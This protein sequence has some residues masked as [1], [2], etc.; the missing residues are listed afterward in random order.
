MKHYI[1]VPHHVSHQI[2]REKSSQLRTDN[3]TCQIY[4]SQ[5]IKS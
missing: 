4:G 3:S 5:W 1:T 2:G